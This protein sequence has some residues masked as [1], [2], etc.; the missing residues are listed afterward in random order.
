MQTDFVNQQRAADMATNKRPRKPY[1]PKPVMRNNIERARESVQTMTDEQSDDVSIFAW[2]AYRN[3]LQNPNPKDFYTLCSVVNTAI[4]GIQQGYGQ[5]TT[6][7]DIAVA[8]LRRANKRIE[9]HGSYALDA[10][11]IFAIEEVLKIRDEQHKTMPRKAL[12]HSL[13][14]QKKIIKQEQFKW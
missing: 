5:Q 12:R 8:G 7:V 10:E 6:A 4:I 9:T 13:T 3:H 1:S 2:L 14:R 11:T